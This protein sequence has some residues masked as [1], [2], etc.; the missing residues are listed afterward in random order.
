MPA[1]HSLMYSTGILLFVCGIPGTTLYPLLLLRKPYD[2]PVS[3]ALRVGIYMIAAEAFIGG[4]L[5]LLARW[6]TK[7][8]SRMRGTSQPR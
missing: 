3:E 7:R 6:I 2:L 5:L 8:Q 4:S 1:W